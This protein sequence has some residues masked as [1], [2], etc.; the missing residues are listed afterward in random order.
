VVLDTAIDRPGDVAVRESDMSLLFTE[1]F[2]GDIR[3]L[4][5]QG[6]MST[7]LIAHPFASPIYLM[8]DGDALYVAD[9]DHAQIDKIVFP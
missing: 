3:K 8:V 7:I 2:R 4:D 6:V 9:R 1:H 5:A